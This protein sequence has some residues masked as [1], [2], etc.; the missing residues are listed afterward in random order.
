MRALTT[1]AIAVVAAGVFVLGV[2]STQTMAQNAMSSLAKDS[3]LE[4]IKKRGQFKVGMTSFVPWAMRDKKGELIGFEIDVANEVAKDME[5]ELKLIPTQFAGIIPALLAGT[6]D[7]IITGIAHSPG[8]NLQV[9]FTIP[10]QTYGSMLV[11]SK[12]LAP[13]VKTVAE[14]NHPG[15]TIGSRRGGTGKKT[16]ERLFPKAKVLY[17][18]DDAQVFQDVINGNIHATF[19]PKPKPLF[20]TAAYS[21]SLHMPVEGFLRGSKQFSGFAIR[22]GDPDFLNFLDNWIRHHQTN[23]WLPE[24]NNFWFNSNNWFDQVEESKNKFAIKKK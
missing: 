11:V 23:G 21:D 2:A 15:I 6:F 22:K 24:R 5:V 1:R 18:D 13:N 4:V 12:K 20:Y 9:N 8:R 10:Y 19:A 7:T 16:I 3:Q 17:F 14:L